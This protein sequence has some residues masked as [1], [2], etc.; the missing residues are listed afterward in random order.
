ML[1]EAQLALRK[2]GIGAS[3]IGAILGASRH[4]T[5]LQVFLSK[6][7]QAEPSEETEQQ[8]LGNHLEAVVGNL[9]ARRLGVEVFPETTLV[10]PD[11]PFVLA[12][13]DFR[14]RGPAGNWLL[15]VKSRG[16][17][18]PAEWGEPGTDEIPF[19]TVAQC[20]Q[21]MAV[22]GALNPE[23]NIERCDVAAFFSI[24]D[25]RVYTVR[26]DP[27]LEAMILTADRRFWHDHVLAGVAPA[28]DG[29]DAAHDYLARKYPTHSDALDFADGDTAALLADYAVA[30]LVF[31]EAEERKSLLEAQIK[32]VVGDRAGLK[33]P[34]GAFTWKLTKS[35]G[36]DY[37]GLVESL[38]ATAEQLAAFARPGIRKIHFAPAKV[39]A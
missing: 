39:T 23:L 34:A 33:G 4:R 38:G 13:P 31:K 24:R 21:E 26:R 27:E 29:S 22:A 8:W 37:K 16:W 30:R 12:T 3:E 10:H 6:T 17:A 11:F 18:D 5:A 19:D 20:A 9:Y 15:Q 7:D 28:L 36:T 32:D 14:V 25:V 1:T 35:N 2:T